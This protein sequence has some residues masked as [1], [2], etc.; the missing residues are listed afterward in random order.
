MKRLFALAFVCPFVLSASPQTARSDNPLVSPTDQAVDRAVS[1]YLS[2]SCHVGLSLVVRENGQNHFYDYGST[3]MGTSE[4]PTPAS[5]YELASVTKTFIGALAAKALIEGQ[6]TLDGDFRSYLKHSYDNLS[7]Q[8]QPITLRTLATHTSGLQRDLPDSDALFSH[9]D[10]DHIGNQLAA[11]NKG[12]T[13]ERS[14]D[15][16]HR[17]TLR[18]K[19]GT[20]FE[21]S[22]LG[23]RVIGY[24]LENTNRAPL[25]T[26]LDEA[27]FH[28]LEMAET[29][30]EISPSMR[31]RLVKP[32]SRYGHLQPYHDSSAGAAYGLYSTPRDMAHYLAWQLNERD[33]IIARAHILIGGTPVDGEGLIWNIG[34]DR[35]ERVLWHGGGSFG[36]TSQMVLYPDDGEGM[37]ALAND[38]CQGSESALK[39]IAMSIHQSMN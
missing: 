22:N 13:R 35:S 26:I 19:P 7:I 2:D 15:A 9:P 1:A 12:F 25:Q 24:G 21:Y 34:R 23:I 30:F 17:V 10:Y 39:T 38:A 8:G 32:Y 37:V 36:E 14:L 18:S 29:G 5:V 6:I 16:L 3:R 11:L 27:V 4:L 31:G 28:P 33:P 20:R